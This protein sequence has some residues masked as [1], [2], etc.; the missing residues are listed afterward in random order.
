[1]LFSA[2]QFAEEHFR[3]GLPTSSTPRSHTRLHNLLVAEVSG[4]TCQP[5]WLASRFGLMSLECYTVQRM[6][7]T[8][9]RSG[10][11]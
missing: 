6:N 2:F 1:M 9:F 3:V 11:F 8:M 4:T 5:L 10:P 7:L